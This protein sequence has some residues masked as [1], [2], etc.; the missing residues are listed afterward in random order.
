[1]LWKIEISCYHGI[2]KWLH[3][4]E[5][6]KKRS[7]RFCVQ[8]EVI[9]KWKKATKSKIWCEWHLTR[10]DSES[11]R[12]PIHPFTHLLTLAPRNVA[13]HILLINKFYKSSVVVMSTQTIY[14]S[15]EPFFFSRH[16]RHCYQNPVW[17][18]TQKKR[19]EENSSF[20]L[21]NVSIHATLFIRVLFFRPSEMLTLIIAQFYILFCK[22]FAKTLF[23]TSYFVILG[24]FLR[25]EISRNSNGMQ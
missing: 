1:M 5:Q 18:Y 17:T 11:P 23:A 9:I 15:L 12:F 7:A 20:K 10:C 19:H 22:Q 3:T 2:I 24:F 6:E 8:R 21:K 16:C 13:P 25:T 14:C 4:R